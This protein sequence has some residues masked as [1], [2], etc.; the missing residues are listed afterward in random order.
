MSIDIITLTASKNYTD[1]QIEKVSIKGV[2]LSRYVQTVNGI[3]PDE[4]GNVEVAGGNV[5]QS[6]LTAEL[7]TALMTYFTNMQTLIQQMAFS[8]DTHIGGTLIANAM[9]IVAALEN[10]E[11]V[12]QPESGIVQTGSILAITSG[13]TVNQSGAVLALA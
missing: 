6:G 2:D 12:E 3:G 11:N 1:K 7:K 8:T 9:A 5:D 13:V 10:S 4:N